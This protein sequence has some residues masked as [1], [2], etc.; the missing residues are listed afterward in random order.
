MDNQNTVAED[1]ID[2]IALFQKIWDSKKFIFKITAIFFV[3]GLLIALF[4]A[5]EY[6]AKTVMIPQ[7]SNKSSGNLGGLAAIAGISLGNASGE[8]I[9]PSLYPKIIES[10]PY[11]Q[12]LL[13]TPLTFESLHHDVTFENYYLEINKPGFLA[14]LKKYT[15]G[16]PS[17]LF[18]KESS[19]FIVEQDST[20]I[21]RIGLEEDGL[22]QTIQNQINVEYNEKEGYVTLSYSMP[23]PLP[24]AQ[25]LEKAQMLLQESI[26]KFKIEKAKDELNFI[27]DRHA[28]AEKDFKS[29]Q[30]ALAQFQDKNRNLY[31]SLPQT[32]LQQLQTEYNLAYNVYSELAKQ[33]ETQKIKVKEETPVFTIIEP[34]TVPN[35]KSK[36][37]RTMI[38]AIWTFL[39]IVISI[40]IVFGRDFM[41]SI[42]KEKE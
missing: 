36:P 33:L 20:A 15:I 11:K 3:I 25:M 37:K 39:G 14:I 8:S 6:T 42:K 22:L 13:N 18:G 27:E 28:E 24:A 30:Y 12:K 41:A 5:K 21:T 19:E 16:L 31:S 40:G 35:Q 10:I 34:V 23:E 1:E 38:L 7:T 26:T 9:S 2:L 17:L 29:K 32:R 4:S